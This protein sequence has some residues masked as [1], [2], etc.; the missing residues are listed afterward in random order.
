MA[1]ELRKR[2]VGVGGLIEDAPLASGATLLTSAG[3]AAITGG[4][5]STEHFPITINPDGDCEIAYITDLTAGNGA[6]GAT[7][8][9][10][11][12]E[13][14]TPQD[15]PQDTPWLH[16]PTLRDIETG[17]LIGFTQYRAGS[18]TLISTTN[19]S[20][21]DMDATNLAVSF[22]A[23]VSGKV[24]VRFSCFFDNNLGGNSYWTLREGGAVIGNC[25]QL[26]SY[27]SLHEYMG[28]A[29]FEVTGLTPGSHHTY[30]WGGVVGSGTMR[31]YTGP[32][33]GAATMEVV[34][35]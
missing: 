2:Q 9:L 4:V 17:S 20:G 25:N 24:L 19:T 10:R 5:G 16:A 14:T 15:W 30:K 33:Y 8:L 6:T 23:P 1:N 31:L 34:A 13:G 7:G 28:V 18:D 3:L 35:V 29:C 26:M 11:G 32:T 12:Q 27:S 22:I 21:V